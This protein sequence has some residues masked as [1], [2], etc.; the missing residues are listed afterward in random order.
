MSETYIIPCV[1]KTLRQIAECVPPAD[2]AAHAKHVKLEP[3]ALYLCNCGYSS[4]WVPED[5][6]PLASDFIDAHMPSASTLERL[7]AEAELGGVA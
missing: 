2:G 4:G 3:L 5:T 1:P 7:R 6:L